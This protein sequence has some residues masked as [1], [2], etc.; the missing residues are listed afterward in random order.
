MNVSLDLKNLKIDQ[1]WLINNRVKLIGAAIALIAVWYGYNG[2]YK[3]NAEKVKVVK[4]K[5]RDEDMKT[6]AF[7]RLA[8]LEKEVDRY[9]PYFTG[10]TDLSVL[11]DR[12][13]ELARKSGLSILSLTTSGLSENETFF[14]GTV[15]IK[16]GGTYHQLGDFI[17]FIENSR[18]FINIEKLQL[19]RTADDSLSIDMLINTLILK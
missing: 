8:R 1:A 2:I 10:N 7:N 19:A 14:Y 16:M 18:Q 5:I 17:S 3:I 4:E 12:I 11:V 9:R 15:S 13:S 6:D